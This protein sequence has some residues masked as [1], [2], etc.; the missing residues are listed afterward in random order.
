MQ[1]HQ[2]RS[3]GPDWASPLRTANWQHTGKTGVFT[4]ILSLGFCSCLK[5]PIDRCLMVPSVS[6]L[7]SDLKP[8][9]S[10][11]TGRGY[12]SSDSVLPAIVE[13]QVSLDF[14]PIRYICWRQVRGSFYCRP[15]IIEMVIA[16][17]ALA[18]DNKNGGQGKSAAI[19]RCWLTSATQ[20]RRAFLP[21]AMPDTLRSR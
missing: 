2:A 12:I 18:W 14:L 11:R 5:L 9:A 13:E 3:Y 7:F 6:I 17:Y 10:S 16:G 1:N 8:Q 20:S 19:L 4:L 21:A 15:L